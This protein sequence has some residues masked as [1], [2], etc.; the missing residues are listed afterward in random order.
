[1]DEKKSPPKS[2][3]TDL[4]HRND[5]RRQTELLK[6]ISSIPKS[7][8]AG[9]RSISHSA[10]SNR[11]TVIGT[12][13]T[14]DNIT[15]RDC[16]AWQTVSQTM[17]LE[18][19]QRRRSVMAIDRG[20]AILSDEE[21]NNHVAVIINKTHG[22]NIPSG[23]IQGKPS[24]LISNSEDSAVELNDDTLEETPLMK[25]DVHII[26]LEN[27]AERFNSNLT[28]GLTSDTVTQHRVKFGQNKLTPARPPSL[29]WM[30]I[31]QLII[32]FNGILWI[33]ALFAFLSY[34]SAFN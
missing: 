21:A 30:L 13:D 16:I 7:S 4:L 8:N 19:E 29:I 20:G 2:S 9:R 11:V 34:V 22:L 3:L 6:T 18:L 32:G 10:S 31:K 25:T 28:N 24:H 26:S 15:A 14:P 12:E 27:L 23:T 17:S 1:M 5:P 33:A